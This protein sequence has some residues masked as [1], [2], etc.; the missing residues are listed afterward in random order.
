MSYLFQGSLI[1]FLDHLQTTKPIVSEMVF[2]SCTLHTHSTCFFMST[3]HIFGTEI[4]VSL[5][6]M[7]YKVIQSQSEMEKSGDFN[8]L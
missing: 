8:H 6:S 1:Y 7:T 4:L 2:A 5:S 3:E